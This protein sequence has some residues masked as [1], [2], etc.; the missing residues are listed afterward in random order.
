[1]SHPTTTGTR[2]ADGV[3]GDWGMVAT[4]HPLA[5]AAGAEMLEAGGSAADAAVAAAAVLCVVDPRSTSVGGDAFALVWQ[6]G[7]SGPVGLAGAG[8]SPAAM[9]ADAVNE[10]GHDRMPRLGPWTVT[11]PGAVSLWE[12]LLERYGRLG[13]ERVLRPAIELA[14]Q[15]F[16]VAP[17]IA[18]EWQE[19]QDRLRGDKAAS[20]LFLPGGRPPRAGDKLANPELGAVLRTLSSGGAR[21]FYQGELA[22]RI[23]AAVEAAGGPLRATDLAA[24]QGATWVEPLR[25]PYRDVD[26]YE[27]PP[28]GQGIVV[29]ETL[30]I[31]EG[32]EASG[33]VES[34]HAAIEALKL[35]FADA[36]AHVADPDVADV[37][38][39][40]LL[41]DG[42]LAER[43]AKID[44][45]AA[46]GPVAT[47]S[48]TVYV[49]V[50]DG[51]GMGCSLIQS[52]YEGFG[53][54]IAVPGTGLLLQNRG[55]NFSTE[56]GHPNRVAGGKRPY[57][58]IIPA[59]LG[60]GDALLGCLGVVGGFMQPQGQTQII[61]RLL[62]DGMGLQAAIDA[63]RARY[64]NGRRVAVEKDFDP[65]IR[66]GLQERGHE[67]E[68]LGRFAGGGAQAVL[69][70][71]G[72]LVGA[73]D[74]RKDGCA[75]APGHDHSDGRH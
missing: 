56:S 20:A 46:R 42:F 50:V 10:A 7:E 17:I 38:V 28:P 70:G 37:P 34:E 71:D 8:P 43:R 73:S 74:P 27:M 66:R 31:F 16:D 36:A 30:G 75:L 1:M 33:P 18:G 29:L 61:R 49:A 24:W 32:V 13:L 57:H 55:S 39:G 15:G 44:P 59:M 69:V 65:E 35:A 25:R 52:L 45:A 3:R 4:S 60:R 2:D 68:P 21:A 58:T 53:S 26:V 22:D 6:A 12:R 9:T 47:G 51:D 48:D 41:S 63:P 23:G 11:V 14:E 62:D 5:A 64:W 19:S 72:G 54:G 40:R 67:I